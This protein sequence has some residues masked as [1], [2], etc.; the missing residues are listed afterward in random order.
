MS[1][2]DGFILL[3]TS[4]LSLLALAWIRLLE[5]DNL[6][7]KRVAVEMSAIS[8]SHLVAAVAIM[9]VGASMLVA[10]AIFL[11]GDPEPEEQFAGDP[12]VA[13]LRAFVSGNATAPTPAIR[14]HVPTSAANETTLAD[15]ETMITQLS[16][17]L[18]A[19]PDNGE[20]WRMLGWS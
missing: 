3:S 13:R 10:P 18:R 5:A 1:V 12:D 4:A 8:R 2:R 19:Q 15:V 20:G 17:R 14:A 7:M 9:L 6:R 11:R 16:E